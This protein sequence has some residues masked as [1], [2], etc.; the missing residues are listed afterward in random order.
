MH[1]QDGL[2]AVAIWRRDHDLAIEAPGPQQG[3]VQDVDAIGRG[4]HDDVGARV[5]TVHFHQQLIQ[6]L[7]TFTIGSARA[8]R[9]STPDCIDFVHE[10]DAWRASLRLLE[11]V[12]YSA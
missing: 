8:H 4:N 7:L 10:Q 11:E 5:E 12:P 9:S 6:R 1:T 2:A 3:W